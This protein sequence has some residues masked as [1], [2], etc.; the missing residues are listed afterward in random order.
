MS[1]RFRESVAMQPLSQRDIDRRIGDLA[2]DVLAAATSGDPLS[3]D[4]LRP[5]WIDA[6]ELVERMR[7]FLGR[8]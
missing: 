6:A 2:S 7:P 1:V 3:G 8:N 5:R 4:S